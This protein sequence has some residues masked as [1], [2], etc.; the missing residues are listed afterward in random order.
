MPSAGGGQGKVEI[1]DLFNHSTVTLT[2]TTDCHGASKKVRPPTP[3]EQRSPASVMAKAQ[4]SN[5]EGGGR[6]LE[7]A[8]SQHL[9]LRGGGG[10]VGSGGFVTVGSIG[11][12]DSAALRITPLCE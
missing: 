3:E 12:H 10:W 6:R 1:R 9:N 4:R 5:L 11:A 7:D 2:V 8:S